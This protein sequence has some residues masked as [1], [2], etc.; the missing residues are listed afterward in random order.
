MWKEVC[1]GS[2]NKN[3]SST[4]SHQ[5]ATELR[6]LVHKVIEGHSIF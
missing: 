2:V 5:K 3:V 6:H 1:T 4:T